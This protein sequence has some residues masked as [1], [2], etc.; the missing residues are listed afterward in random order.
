MAYYICPVCRSP[1][2]ANFQDKLPLMTHAR[3]AVS[4]GV[5]I[6]SLMLAGA[7]PETLKLSLFYFPIWGLL[8]LVHWMNQR[9]Q[10]KCNTCNFDPF[11]Y[12][13]DWR[14]ARSAVELKLS[15]VK[16]EIMASMQTATPKQDLATHSLDSAQQN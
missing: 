16:S 10:T 14:A 9:Q 5:L 11:L 6:G 12:Q 15:T 8:E 7:G 4:L 3:I 1:K 13:R 2:K